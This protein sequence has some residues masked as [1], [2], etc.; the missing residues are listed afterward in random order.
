[1]NKV[2]AT[3]RV[4]E[5]DWKA[6]K[7]WSE[8]KGSNA[9]SELIK[10]IGVSL[11][12]IDSEVNLPSID[13]RIDNYLDN[14][15]GKHLDKR[16]DEKLASSLDKN[17]DVESKIQNAVASQI[18]LLKAELQPILEA[19]RELKELLEKQSA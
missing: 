19:E 3:F 18:A 13:S 15:L 2:L 5:D 4:D 1:M 7:E 10:F 17:L 6:F 8:N 9:S 14:N 11:G 16:I 12:R